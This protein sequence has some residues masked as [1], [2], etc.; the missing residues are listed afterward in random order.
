MAAPISNVFV[1]GSLLAD[2]V[3]R[4]LLGRVPSSSPAVLP[5]QS[6]SL[7][8]ALWAKA[9]SFLF[10]TIDFSFS[11]LCGIALIASMYIQFKALIGL[12]HLTL[13]INIKT[14]SR[15]T[16]TSVYAML[17]FWYLRNVCN[18]FILEILMKF[19]FMF[20]KLSKMNISVWKILNIVHVLIENTVAERRVV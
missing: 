20:Y 4:A 6:V 1:Y 7:S 13:V 10:L 14:D 5:N 9:Y 16:V 18:W 8:F 11:R 17:S 15:V 19:V 2:D 3:V 12:S